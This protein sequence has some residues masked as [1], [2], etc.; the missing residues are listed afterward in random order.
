MSS[1]LN[2]QDVMEISRVLGARRGI[3]ESYFTTSMPEEYQRVLG[4]E[5]TRLTHHADNESLLDFAERNALLL[6][7]L[8]GCIAT[9]ASMSFE[10]IR[11]IA[12][13]DLMVDIV[14]PVVTAV[15]CIKFKTGPTKGESEGGIDLIK[16]K[17]LLYS[18]SM[19]LS[20]AW[21]V[22]FR[23]K[24]TLPIEKV[25]ALI[26]NST[27]KDPLRQPNMGAP[28]LCLVEEQDS[29]LKFEA[30][31]LLGHISKAIPTNCSERAL[32]VS[33]VCDLCFLR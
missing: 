7:W 8:E 31:N 10:T 11:Q 9:E 32:K 5:F 28:F 26:K 20:A 13:L 27:F 30:M 24:S 18:V 21:A 14:R 2:Q 22:A 1:G 33:I 3:S 25:C 23:E 16:R 17:V 6:A 19:R 4:R 15:S 12:D 29:I